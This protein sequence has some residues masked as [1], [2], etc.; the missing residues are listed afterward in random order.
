MKQ[1]SNNQKASK[2]S[3]KRKNKTSGRGKYWNVPNPSTRGRGFNTNAPAAVSDDL[4][5]FVRFQPGSKNASLK[6]T[7]C[8]PLYQI[9]SNYYSGSLV[10]GGL[11]LTP[12]NSFPM[13][14]LTA[15]GGYYTAGGTDSARDFISPVFKL[16]GNSFVRYRITQC[17]FCYEP[18]SATD[19]KDRLVFAYAN[20]PEH[21]MIKLTP[22]N[23]T[24][25][26]LL[27][28]SDSVAFAPWRSWEMDVSKEIN[29]NLLY[30]Y[31]QDTTG[32]SDNRF[33]M[34]GAIGCIAS[35]EPTETTA[36]TIY[37]ILYGCF[38]IEF[39]E[40]CPLLQGF[41]PSVLNQVKKLGYSKPCS[42]PE[43]KRCTKQCKKEFEAISAKF[44][45][46]ITK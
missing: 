11:S 8:I 20:D 40:F 12:T 1:N 39:V 33:N 3:R 18:Q 17:K 43:C 35:V 27:A 32:E 46:N 7:A 34:F 19:I 5:Q 15:T 42:D 45:S 37:G 9:N 13:A 10:K 44:S 25:D 41:T 4:Q 26:N 16:I 28:L 29:Q 24:Q 23:M 14:T 36:M 30:T 6:M 21:P 2:K 22:A 38:T 31:N